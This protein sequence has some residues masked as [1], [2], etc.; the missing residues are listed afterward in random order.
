[1]P[2]KG[3][4]GG[5][6]YIE[7]GSIEETM[8]GPLW[9]RA[10]FSKQYP[11]I[12]KDPKAVEIKNKMNYDFSELKEFLGEWR[13]IGLLVRAKNLDNEVKKY[14][15][16]HPEATVVNIAA[17]LDTTFHRID[18][19]KITW[20]DLDLPE[21]IEFRKQFLPE[22]QRNK[23]MAQSAFDFSWMDEIKFEPE[24]GAFFLSGGFIYYYTEE[25]IS[26]LVATLAERF[27][28]GGMAFD[29]VNKIAAKVINK[30]AKKYDTDLS[31][32][33]PIGKPTKTI[34]NWSDKIEIEDWYTMYERTS[35]NPDWQKKTRK[36]IKISDF[37]NVAKII[38]L[39]FT[40]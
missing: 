2:E 29:T 23:Y 19:G 37:L 38:S 30:K 24:K 10:T 15:E 20:Y 3:K 25:E 12:L 6:D 26:D 17:G 36:A 11:D 40:K 4:V 39:R 14:L 21:G 5:L 35:I 31:F 28:G 34:P 22:T 8:I 27:P 16:D 33:L 18:N 32:K 7:K 9:A 1:M 13:G